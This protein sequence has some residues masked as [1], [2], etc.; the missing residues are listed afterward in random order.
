MEKRDVVILSKQIEHRLIERYTDESL[1]NQYAWWMIESVSGKTKAELIAEKEI[2]FTSEQID[3][4]E[5]YIKQ[6]LEEKKPLQYLL[7]RVPF[8]NI[9][10]LVEPPTLI[11][12]PETEEMVYKITDQL[13]KLEHKKLN[14]LDIGTGSGCIAISLAKILPEATVYATDISDKALEL[15]KKNAK[16]NDTAK[17]IFVNSDVYNDIPHDIKFDFIVS[18]PPY[19]TQEEWNKLDESVTKWEDKKALVANKEGLAIIERIVHQAPE[20]LTVNEEMESKNMNRLIIEIGYLQGQKTQ[21][22]FETAGFTYVQ[23]LKD[24][25]NKDRFVTGRISNVAIQTNRT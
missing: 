8:D 9:K 3:T 14:I 16:F 4:L 23:I 20:F 17:V 6:Q 15:A 12:R 7:G 21:K 10:V 5:K 2:H 22:I 24:L 25:E 1:C 13:N 18:N 19:V 11:P